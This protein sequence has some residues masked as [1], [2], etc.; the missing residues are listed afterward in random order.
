[1]GTRT[2]LALMFVGASAFG[3][4]LSHAAPDDGRHYPTVIAAAV[5]LYPQIALAA[6][7]S[8]TVEIRVSVEKGAVVD[9]Q[10][11]SVEIQLTDPEHRAVY[12]ER[13]KMKVSPYL[14]NPAIANV[15]TW[16]FQPEDH[17]AFLVTFIYEI[18]GK[19]TLHPRTQK[20]ELNLPLFVKVIASPLKPTCSDCSQ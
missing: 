6:H 16:K 9:A 10:V 8:G 3:Q 14:S 13:A 15:K 4:N 19:E 7:I 2:M 5:P 11:K 20:V 18:S 17:G 12:D 1:M